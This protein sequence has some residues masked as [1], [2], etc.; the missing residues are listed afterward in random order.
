ME[1]ESEEKEWVPLIAA[2]ISNSHAAHSLC[3]ARWASKPTSAL[4]ITN[5]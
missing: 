5:C 2:C 4:G 1:V 3:S